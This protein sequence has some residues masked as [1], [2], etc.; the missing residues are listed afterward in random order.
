MNRAVKFLIMIF[1]LFSFTACGNEADAKEN[2]VDI[3]ENETVEPLAPEERYEVPEF[4]ESIFN[5]AEAE[6][7]NGAY[8]DLS[9]VSKGYVAVKAES[10]AR[11]KFQVITDVTYNY[12]IS[13]EGEVSI[14]PLQSGDGEYHFRVMENISD[15]RYAVLFET[16]ANVTLE[17]EFQPYLRSSDYAYYTKD[18]EC[19][20]LASSFSETSR[21]ANEVI[22]KVYDYVCDHITYDKPKA[23]NIKSGY[24]PLPDETLAT[25]KGIC[26]DYASLTAAMLRSQGIPTKVIFGYVSPNDLYHA[27]NMFYTEESG[28]V[29]VEFKVSGNEW[30]RMDLT[31]SANGSD[32]RFIGD[33]SN[34]AQVYEY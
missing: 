3:K 26:F 11:L 21:T 1:L 20:K 15:N 33:G 14:F 9:S 5:E 6:Y 24:L 13:S 4:N 8:I 27:W 25:G 30:T 34:Y 28:W 12:N 10:D 31:F 2:E 17:D 29:T 22:S 16:S 18:S 7:K 23:E 19:V 32:Q